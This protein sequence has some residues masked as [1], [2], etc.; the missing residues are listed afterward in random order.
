MIFFMCVIPKPD[1]CKSNVE[2]EPHDG[3]ACWATQR[4][5]APRGEY[6][7]ALAVCHPITFDMYFP[8]DSFLTDCF[9]HLDASPTAIQVS[10]RLPFNDR[11]FV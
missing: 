2:L 8:G 10:C 6:H 1:D 5:A 9:H 7:A 4:P 11:R 3:E